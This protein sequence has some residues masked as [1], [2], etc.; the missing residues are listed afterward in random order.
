MFGKHIK[1]KIKYHSDQIDK[2]EK[3]TKGDWIDLRAAKDYSLKQDEFALIDLGVSMELPKGYEAHLIPRSSTYKNWKIIQTN[4]MG[5]ID[6]SYKGDDDVWMMPVIAMKDTEIH[7]NDRV[8]Q[9]RIVKS[10]PPIEFVEAESLNNPSRGGI[11]STGV[12]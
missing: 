3:I 2:L 10:Q 5:L 12:K 9:F 4:S 6:N 11:G 1:I 7:V 8:G